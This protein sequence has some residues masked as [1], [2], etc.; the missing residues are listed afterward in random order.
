MAV[1]CVQV[2][3]GETF[4]LPLSSAVDLH[5]ADTYAARLSSKFDHSSCQSDE[6]PRDTETG[7]IAIAVQSTAKAGCEKVQASSQGLMING[8]TRCRRPAT[9]HQLG[10]C[11]KER[12]RSI[13]RSGLGQLPELDSVYM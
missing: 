4:S 8:A 2:H 3:H 6:C 12:M 10:I 9:H 13:K 11:S 5:L 1:Q 7:C